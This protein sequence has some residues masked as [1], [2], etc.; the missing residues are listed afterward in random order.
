MIIADSSIG[1]DSARTYTSVSKEASHIQLLTTSFNNTLVSQIPTEDEAVSNENP[2]NE[3]SASDKAKKDFDNI[4]NKMKAFATS[5]SY[6]RKL[7]QDAIRKIQTECI[8]YLLYY[9]FYGHSPNPGEYFTTNDLKNS[10]ADIKTPEPAESNSIAYFYEEHRYSQLFMEAED[11]S[12]S[13]TGKV[14]TADGRE[15]EFNLDMEMSRS[16]SSTFDLTSYKAVAYTDPLVINFD[17]LSAE[18]SD[19]KIKFDLDG[20]GKDESISKLSSSSG[21]LALDKNNDGK[22]NDGTELF[23][24][25]SGDGFKDLA[26][27]DEDGNGWIDEADSIY[28]K[29]RIYVQNDDGTES[30]YTL[31]DKGVGA[32]CLQ[33]KSTEFSLNSLSTNNTNAKIR[34]TGI[35]LYENGNVGTMQH[36][37]LAQ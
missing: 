23:G 15:I 32:I 18:V 28:N 6:E 13:T 9:L 10:S 21:Y 22:I 33:N 1:M 26:A 4:F 24:T 34:S 31:T 30:L 14:T 2:S 27:Y 8:N 35:F 37:D 11:T 3:S 12:F 5:H 19:I 17:S 7:E 36:L 16:F 25:S 29:L 20:D